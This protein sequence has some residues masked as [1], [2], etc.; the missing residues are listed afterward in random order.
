MRT[1]NE[2]V[3]HVRRVST[4][5]PQYRKRVVVTGLGL[6]TC[7]GVGAKKVWKRLLNGEC[8][9]TKIT[10]PGFEKIPCQV[11]GYVPANE[12]NIEQLIPK[13][14][15]R[16]MSMGSIYAL[17][18]ANEAL[19]DADWHPFTDEEKEYTGVAVGMGMSKFGDIVDAGI[20]LKNRGYSRISPFFIPKVLLN[21]PAGHVSLR[22]G[23]KGPNHVVNTAC[24][25]GL[26]AIGD[27]SRF[28][29]N[30]DANVMVCG[31]TE[32]S[33]GPL[34]IAGFA[35]MRALSTSFNDRPIEA[36]RPFDKD[37]DG[38][39]MADG[40]GVVVL[41][42]YEHAKNRGA[43]IYAEILGYGLSGDSFHLTSPDSEGAGARRSMSA[44][45]QNAGLCPQ[46]VTHI[47]AHATSTPLGDV[48]ECKAVFRVFG[49]NS[50]NILMTSTKGA[51]GHLLG[52]AGSVEAIFTI[53]A[54][55]HGIVPPTLNLFNP[56][57]GVDLN[58]V[59]GRSATWDLDKRIG[60]TNSFGFGGTNS[61]MCIGSVNE[62]HS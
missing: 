20:T 11:A 1:I 34:A 5:T 29:Q 9:I 62:A 31:G 49:E 45:L 7:L 14:E 35:R 37:R 39:V 55:Y 18:A 8:G 22:Y 17:A 28:I 23:L 47:N 16:E 58:I 10:E 13:S 6:V 12:L 4:S 44:A 33:V 43:K 56:D 15:L 27:G 54:C 50:K 19:E 24:A 26:H 48:A 25:T 40:S 61:S 2:L 38:F 57:T 42:E 30:G 36:S 52:A 60:L 53:L 59:R 21:M 32:A 41:E 46:D 51:I 3:R